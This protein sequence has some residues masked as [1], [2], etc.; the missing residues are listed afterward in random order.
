MVKVRTN[1][2]FDA[3]IFARRDVERWEHKAIESSDPWPIGEVRR[4]RRRLFVIKSAFVDNTC[5]I[6]PVSLEISL[7]ISKSGPKI[8]VSAAADTWHIPSILIKVDMLIEKIILVE[9]HYHMKS[10]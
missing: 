2:R 6:N 1:V 4:E 10:G 3:D 9:Q 7:N 8:F 5:R